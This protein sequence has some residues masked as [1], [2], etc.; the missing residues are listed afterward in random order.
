[1][2]ITIQPLADALN[3][4]IAN[5]YHPDDLRPMVESVRSLENERDVLRDENEL[6]RTA[7]DELLDTVREADRQILVLREECLSH[8]ETVERLT[9]VLG[10]LNDQIEGAR[11]DQD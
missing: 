3:A 8:L 10:R 2:R 5:S 9:A 7:V 11:H 1:M 4:K 6:L